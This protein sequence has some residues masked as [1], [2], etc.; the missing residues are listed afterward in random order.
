MLREE[1][2][3]AVAAKKF[4]IWSAN[5]INDG[6]EILTGVAAGAR[7]AD[8]K[9]PADTVNFR[10]EQRLREFWERLKEEKSKSEK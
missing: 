6:I 2:I 10:V 5:T 1:V 7:G 8:G 9:F 4:S 3:E